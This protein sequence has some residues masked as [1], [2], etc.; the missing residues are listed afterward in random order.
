MAINVKA[1]WEERM[2]ED[3]SSYCVVQCP[4]EQVGPLIG[5]A[6]TSIRQ[7]EMETGA[8]IKVGKLSTRGAR[9]ICIVGDMEMQEKAKALI[10]KRLDQLSGRRDATDVMSIPERCIGAVIG[11][12]GCNIRQL[13]NSLGVKIDIEHEG[14]VR[15]LT[16][17]GLPENIALARDHFEALIL[18]TYRRIGIF[19]A[20]LENKFAAK[21]AKSIA[22]N[23]FAAVPWEA[24]VPS[25]E[26][27]GTAPATDHRASEEALEQC[28]IHP[29]TTQ[30]ATAFGAS[31]VFTPLCSSALG[32][33]AGGPANQSS[34]DWK[35][36]QAWAGVYSRD[37][38]CLAYYRTVR[39]CCYAH[40][41]E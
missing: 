11:R 7:I 38:L 27:L 26:V 35:L 41:E 34:S 40:D 17:R 29:V 19:N 9:S 12:A 23:P 37:P 1:E 21:T 8:S 20:E 10:E 18:D 5:K 28:G 36:A 33:C 3:P 22:K 13:H 6:G 32:V 16:M 24:G 15:K 39:S 2:V 30:V 25:V 4:D 31:G 14:S